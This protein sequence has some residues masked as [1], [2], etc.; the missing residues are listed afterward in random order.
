VQYAYDFTMPIGSPVIAAR[1]GT[2]LLVE[3]RFADGTRRLGEE[4]YVNVRHPD[5]TIAGY[6]HLTQSGALVEIGQAVARGQAIGRSGDSGSSS[7]PHLHF[8]VQRCQG[9]RTIPVTF[10]NTRP[11]A[12]GL[13]EGETYAAEPFEGASARARMANEG[14][15]ATTGRNPG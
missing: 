9:C 10:R 11:H 5:G 1:A 7:E 4:N 6:V 2:V 13:V 12:R 8:H 15:F 14:G 3:E